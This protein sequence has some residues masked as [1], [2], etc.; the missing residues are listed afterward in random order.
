MAWA[1][2]RS[3]HSSGRSLRCLVENDHSIKW[4]YDHSDSLIHVANGFVFGTRLEPCISLRKESAT[5]AYLQA[6]PRTIIICISSGSNR[7][8]SKAWECHAPC[9]KRSSGLPSLA[10]NI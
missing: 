9:C 10:F 6:G 4:S 8:L 3:A 7:Y 2:C 1:E 5:S